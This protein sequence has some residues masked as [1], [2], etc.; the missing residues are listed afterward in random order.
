[1][2]ALSCWLVEATS[3][4]YQNTTLSVHSRQKRAANG[5]TVGTA[6]AKAFLA[7]AG[8]VAGAAIGTATFGTGAPLAFA[9]G[10]A[11]GTSA[12]G[13]VKCKKDTRLDT[14]LANQKQLRD[15]LKEINENV[16]E[17]GRLIV[18]VEEKVEFGAIVGLYGAEIISLRTAKRAYYNNLSFKS[19]GAIVKNDAQ[20]RF[21]NVALGHGPGSQFR[22]LEALMDMIRKGT[23]IATGRQGQSIYDPSR[24]TQ[25]IFCKPTVKQYFN[26]LI[27]EGANILFVAKKMNDEKITGRMVK[28]YQD[29]ILENERLYENVCEKGKSGKGGKWCGKHYAQSCDKCGGNG[30]EEACSGGV[31]PD[32][33]FNHIYIRGK[34]T[35]C[36]DTHIINCGDCGWG[37]IQPPGGKKTWSCRP[38]NRRVYLDFDEEPLH[39]EIGPDGRPTAFGESIG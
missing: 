14:I 15:D 1:M 9:A 39:I 22:G 28:K 16:M 20:R 19:N 13:N 26:N 24:K 3:Q 5:C 36:R 30:Q 18:K 21:M 32:G 33:R 8:V 38:M 35:Y 29:Y 34:L 27:L 25:H 7:I 23:G 11:L 10:S 2:I 17:N 31:R 4:S 12:L 37:W 6:A